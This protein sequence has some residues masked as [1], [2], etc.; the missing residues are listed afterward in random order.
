MG[1]FAVVFCWV[2]ALLMSSPMSARAA[3]VDWLYDVDVPVTD[4]SAE[5]RSAAFRQALLVA[6]EANHRIERRADRI[7]R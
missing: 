1:R 2:I 3:S 7:R 4:Q 6:L 5:V